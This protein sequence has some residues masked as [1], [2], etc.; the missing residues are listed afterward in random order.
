V[1][2]QLNLT[3]P[4]QTSD[5]VPPDLSQTEGQTSRN[6]DFLQGK[7]LAQK[8][9]YS[10]AISYLEKARKKDPKVTEILF[11]LGYAR[12]NTG[13][14]A[15]AIAAYEEF[16]AKSPQ[17]EVYFRLGFLKL[18]QG[19]SE[20]ALSPLEIAAKERPK[21]ANAQAL[22]GL[23]LL[24][25]GKAAEAIPPLRRAVE[26]D[27]TNPMAPF[28]LGEAYFTTD[29]FNQSKVAY[30]E[31]LR[32][33]STQELAHLGVGKS[34]LGLMKPAEALPFLQK[35]TATLTNEVQAPYYLGLAYK[36]L[37]QTAQAK[38]AFEKALMIDSTHARSHYELALIHI[39]EKQYAQAQT[40]Y[41]A[42]QKYNPRLAARIAPLL[43]K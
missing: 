43:N 17:P 35:A 9:E 37:S 36:N 41:E 3:T 4:T 38:S 7:A 20:S 23:C 26:L 19:N 8:G 21:W 6:E 1:L 28:W 25:L 5:L 11:W 31:A 27:G 29:S 16:V 22:Y 13:D 12:E 30:E 10:K 34:L 42:L 33:D 24:S 2:G 32:R 15:G 18:R 40:H 14:L 39:Q